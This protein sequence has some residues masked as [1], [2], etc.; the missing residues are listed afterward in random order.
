MW[1]LHVLGD[2]NGIRLMMEG[3]GSQVLR[4]GRCIISS[5]QFQLNNIYVK[6][7]RS[8][9]GSWKLEFARVK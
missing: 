1:F 9:V 2:N 8:G 3:F 4:V 5:Y 6:G 7:L